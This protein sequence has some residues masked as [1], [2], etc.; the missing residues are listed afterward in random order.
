MFYDFVMAV[1]STS[2]DLSNV[3]DNNECVQ[4]D[5]EKQIL[6][7]KECGNFLNDLRRLKEEL[8]EKE[9]FTVKEIETCYEDMFRQLKKQREECVSAINEEYSNRMKYVQNMIDSVE[10]I[11]TKYRSMSKGDSSDTES[12]GSGVFSD[13]ESPLSDVP[14]SPETGAEP[15]WTFRGLETLNDPSI[16]FGRNGAE[17]GEF[18]NLRGIAVDYQNRIYVADCGNKRIQVSYDHLRW[19]LE[20]V[21]AVAA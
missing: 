2:G 14:S 16:V 3:N 8:S 9:A 4:T 1:N 12:V 15:G 21:K 6:K 13:L 7:I 10:A 19:N 17:S 18:R 5:S 11:E 20:L